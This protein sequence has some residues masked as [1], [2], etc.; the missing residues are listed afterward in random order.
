MHIKADREICIGAGNCVFSAPEVFD[1][2][3]DGTV[4]LLDPDPTAEHD[5]SVRAAVVRC[6]SGAISLADPD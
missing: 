2:H 5:E 1:Q 3:D 4:A 6:P